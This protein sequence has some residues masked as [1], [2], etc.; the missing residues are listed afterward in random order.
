MQTL[1]SANKTNI[2]GAIRGTI[3]SI[4]PNCFSYRSLTS[5]NSDENVKEEATTLCSRIEMLPRGES[6]GSAFQTWMGHGFPVQRGI[7]FHTINRLRKRRL[8]K[9][10]LEVMFPLIFLPLMFPSPNC[11]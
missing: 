9:R 3:R 2:F 5:N 11:L 1:I 4:Q 10:A 7:I 6:I 8:N